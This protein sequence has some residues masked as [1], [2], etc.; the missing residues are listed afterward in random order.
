[1]I[2]MKLSWKERGSYIKNSFAASLSWK[3]IPI[4]RFLNISQSCNREGGNE[5]DHGKKADERTFASYVLEGASKADI[6]AR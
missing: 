3:Q 4:V 1:M 5:A 6:S 2:S